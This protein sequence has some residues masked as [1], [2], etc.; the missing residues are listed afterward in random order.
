M[1]KERG[2][3][4]ILLLRLVLGVIFGYHSIPKLT[5]GKEMA[6]GMNMPFAFVVILGIAEL[7]A[8]VGSILGIYTKYAA[9]IMGIVMI[10]AL[11]YKIVKWKIPFAG[12]DK[13]GWEFDALILAAAIVLFYSGAGPVSLDAKLFGL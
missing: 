3:F 7:L 13:T 6:S 5:K 2:M 11:F 9:I 4:H 8:A 12:M 1:R 10:G